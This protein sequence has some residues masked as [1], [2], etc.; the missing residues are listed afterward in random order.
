MPQVLVL[1]L[2]LFNIYLNDLFFFLDCNVCNFADDTTPFICNKNLDFVLSE[3][4]RNSSI[5]IDWFQNSYMKMNSDKCHL[6]VAG[7]KFEQ[8]RAK[9]GTDLIWESNSVKLLVITIDNHLKFDKHISLLCA[10]A[11]R[12]F[13]PFFSVKI[14]FLRFLFLKFQCFV[15]Y[16]LPVTKTLSDVILFRLSEKL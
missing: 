12:K 5:A 16:I 14:R 2:L 11:N 1:D 4:E 6:L 8:I 10:K 13:F 3:L 9:I 15:Y 7:H